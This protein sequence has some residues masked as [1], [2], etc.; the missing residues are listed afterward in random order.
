APT[1]FWIDFHVAESKYFRNSGR[2]AAEQGSYACHEFPRSKGFDNV[3]VR[4]GLE[5]QDFVDFIPDSTEDDD[6]SV[7]FR[8]AQL[9]TDFKAVHVGKP[10]IDQQQTWL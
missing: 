2:C 10:K 9:F 3:I 5:Q 7:D 4:A 8:G 1:P 6:G